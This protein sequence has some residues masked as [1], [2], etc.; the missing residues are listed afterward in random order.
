M[1]WRYYTD[2]DKFKEEKYPPLQ[3]TLLYGVKKGNNYK[4]YKLG[5]D[6]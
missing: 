6:F 1:L 2:L 3:K 5:A 4:A